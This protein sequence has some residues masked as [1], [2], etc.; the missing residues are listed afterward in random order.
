MLY[1]YLRVLLRKVRCVFLEN[2]TFTTQPED[3]DELHYSKIYRWQRFV[4]VVIYIFRQIF[5]PFITFS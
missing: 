1:L 3:K 2:F 5:Y 4:L